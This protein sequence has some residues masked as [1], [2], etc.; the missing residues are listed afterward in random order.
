MGLHGFGAV[1]PAAIPLWSVAVEEQFYLTWPVLVYCCGPAQLRRVCLGCLVAAPLVRLGLLFALHPVSG[2][3]LMP[4]RIDALAVGALVAVWSREPGS[5]RRW[6]RWARPV[7]LAVVVTTIAIFCYF[8]ELSPGQKLFQL[9]VPTLSP[10][11]AAALLVIVLTA[12]PD[13][14]LHKLLNRRTLRHVAQYSYGT[15]LLHVP[16]ALY[17]AGTGILERDMLDRW[18]GTGLLSTIV[19]GVIMGA[20]S[21]VAGAVSWH[22]LEGPILRLKRY[23]PYEAPIGREAR[24]APAEG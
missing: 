9:V 12:P 22:L 10:Y 17:L 8:G 14:G 20:L 15:Y 23:F 7:A 2:Y 18:F 6:A 19:W 21:L 1:I 13:G 24:V 5:L 16:L 3:V 4:A 11:C